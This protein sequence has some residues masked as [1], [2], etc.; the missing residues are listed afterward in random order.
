MTAKA[1]HTYRILI[2]L[3]NKVSNIETRFYIGTTSHNDWY[4]TGM[5]SN[6]IY[7]K[8]YT[9]TSDINFTQFSIIGAGASNTS[10]ITAVVE[11]AI[12][13]V[14][15]VDIKTYQPYFE[16]I[17][18]CDI[19]GHQDYIYNNGGKWFKHKEVEKVILDS[20]K[21]DGGGITGTNAYYI[22]TNIYGLNDNTLPLSCSNM[23]Q[24][25]SFNDRT[26][27]LDITYLQNGQLNIRTANNTT[28]DWSDNTKRDDWLNANKPIVYYVL[29][30]PI[31]EEITEPTLINQLNAIKYGAES[32]YGQTNIMI[33]SEELQPTLKVQTLDKIGD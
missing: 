26:N 30:T 19:E 13:D 16:P 31:E 24:P 6:G 5:T 29:A 23:F 12:Y 1:N 4:I 8:D 21:R 2:K 20:N 10:P 18:L 32:Y 7:I 22:R 3:S 9:P 27:G 11:I 28:I 25:C 14:T 33:T 17:Q 15:N